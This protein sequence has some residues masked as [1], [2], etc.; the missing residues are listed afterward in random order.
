MILA[1]LSG[2]RKKWWL[3]VLI[4]I[5]GTLLGIYLRRFSITEPYF[6]NFFSPGFNIG[7]V[8]LAF[9][10]FAIRFYFHCNLGTIVGGILGIWIIL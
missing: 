6:R 9:A 7:E 8:D 5:L 10:D 3:L 2:I 1:I 4:V